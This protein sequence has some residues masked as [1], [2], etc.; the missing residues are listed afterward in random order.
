[1]SGTYNTIWITRTSTLPKFAAA[2]IWTEPKQLKVGDK[3]ALSDQ[4]KEA[5]I[6]IFG[7]DFVSQ[8]TQEAE[9]KTA[10]LETA[11]VA[12]KGESETNEPEQQPE[13]QQIN[14]DMAE[15]AAEVGKQF[16]ANLAP[17]AEAIATMA[18]ELKELKEWKER[19]DKE[20][21][22]KDKTETPRYIFEWKRASDSEDT[23]VT[24][25][26]GLK[27]QKPKEAQANTGDV[28]AQ[29]FNK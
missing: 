17:M 15:L 23:V 24:E 18:T 26:D 6:K 27:N 11:G 10:E 29:T 14:I 2:N 1:M 8:M 13:P 22:I 21:G 25:D 16:T 20:Q 28:W 19:Q 9:D 12:H 3:M 5:A 7:D 4:Q